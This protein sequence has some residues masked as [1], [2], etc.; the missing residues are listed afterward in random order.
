MNRIDFIVELERLL[1]DIP[2]DERREALE[3]YENYF[4]EAGAENEATVLRELESP[5]KVADKIKAGLQ[6]GEEESS[7]YRE[8]GYADTRFEEKEEVVRRAQQTDQGN[9]AQTN[10]KPWTSNLLKIVLI[11]AIIIV[12]F[13]VISSVAGV[14]LG[15]ICAVLAV[16]FGLVVA[17]VAVAI[18]GICVFFYGFAYFATY[19]PAA[20]LT[21]GIGMILTGVGVAGTVLMIGLCVKLFPAVF[22][23]IVNLCSRLLHR[24]AV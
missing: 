13:P 3:Y 22:R 5:K 16:I 21:I 10:K 18:A 8:T 1:G 17:A 20:F 11:I 4:A 7:E 19:V 6:G 23:G 15:V 2:A 9:A 24:K 14:L 12:G